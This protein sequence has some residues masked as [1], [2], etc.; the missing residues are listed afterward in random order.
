MNKSKIIDLS[1]KTT[2]TIKSEGLSSLARKARNY[3]SSGKLL[4]NERQQVKDILIINGCSLSHPERYRVDHQLEQLISF[5]LSADKVYYEELD[6]EKLKY[7]HGFIFFRCP[8]TPTV[9]EFIK[10]AHYFNKT[11]FFDIDDLVINRKYTNTIPFVAAMNSSDKATYDDGVIRMEKTLK[12][13]DYLITS[14]PALARELKSNYKKEVLVN[15]NVASE[16][17]AALS[18]EA[19]RQKPQRKDKFV[20]GYLSGSITHNPDFELIKKPLLK[21]MSEFP[22]V[23]LEVMGYLDLPADFSQFDSRIIRKNFT[24]WEELPKIIAGL[25]INLAPLEK[26]IFNEAKSENKWTEAALVKTPTIASNFGAFKEV[27]KDGTTGFLASSE[28]EWYEKIKGVINNP[29]KAKQVAD[30]AYKKAK[31]E[32]ITTYSGL[33]LS[34]YISSH[35]SRSIGFILP[36]TN[37]SGGVNVVIKHCNI[38]RNNGWDVSIIN[39]DKSS[40]NVCTLDGEINVVSNVGYKFSARFESLVATLYSTLDFAKRYPEV[41]NRIYLVQNFETDFAKYGSDAKFEANA[42]YNSFADIRYIT[43]SKWCKNWLK[44]SFNKNALYAPNGISTSRFTPK[45]RKMTG[46]IKLLVEGNSLDYYKNVDESF[47]IIEKLD[48]EK[49]EVTYLSYEGEPKRWYHIDNFLHRVPADEVHKVYE[50]SDI[51]IKSSILES[52]SYPPL[53]MMATGGYCVVAPNDGNIEY[54]ENTKNCLFYK[55]GDIDSAV[56][57]IEQLVSDKSLRNKLAKGA[58]KTVCSR[59]WE[60]LEKQILKLYE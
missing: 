33:G 49:F 51:L 43:I 46:K 37:I 21:I 15:R 40:D 20:I 9:E 47:R 22:N 19:L 25:D 5:G 57:K 52:F 26:S 36:T 13:C 38:L 24:N 16:K 41:K 35:L 58:E 11:C 1:K 31:T 12:Q 56:E 34:K 29:E 6:I 60:A 17:M 27:I 18:F 10:K 8:I 54:L 44:Q 7:Y 55:P 45:P 50:Q 4:N 14:T 30:A 48:P 23:Y 2:Q 39:M 28:S 42:T 53:E 3:I 32:Y 59:D